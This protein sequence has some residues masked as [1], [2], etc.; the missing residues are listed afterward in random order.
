MKIYSESE[1]GE[2]PSVVGNF[3]FFAEEK[4][5]IASDKSGS[6]N[7]ANIGSIQ[8]IDD[9]INGNGVFAKAGED[10]FDDYWA[11]FGK[12]EIKNDDGTYK[13]MSSFKEYLEFKGLPEN[14][15]NPK[16]SKR[17]R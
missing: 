6:G 9:I 15:N 11:N 2:I 17:S 5:K 10:K 16:K 14:L 12:I 13:K 3:V 1:L 7:T 4:W 8:C